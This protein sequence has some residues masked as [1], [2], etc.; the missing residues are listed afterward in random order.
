M[1][2][3][4]IYIYIYLLSLCVYLCTYKRPRVE[5]IPTGFIVILYCQNT[6]YIMYIHCSMRARQIVIDV[7]Q[8]TYDFY[9]F[10]RRTRR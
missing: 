10:P 6:T 5:E 8:K 3:P 4:C 7:E 1:P 2:S 9:I